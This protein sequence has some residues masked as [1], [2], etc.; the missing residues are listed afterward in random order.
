MISRQKAQAYLDRW[1]QRWNLERPIG[2]EPTPEPWQ[3][4]RFGGDLSWK[5]NGKQD[6]HT[7]FHRI[8]LSLLAS[9]RSR[10]NKGAASPQEKQKGRAD[11]SGRPSFDLIPATTYIPA[12][13]PVQYHRLPNPVGATLLRTLEVAV[14][15]QRTR[16]GS[17]TGSLAI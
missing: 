15:G 12:Q 6:L 7:G 11:F 1:E 5:T 4:S 3:G 16:P 2:I 8:R 14:H 9:A 13:L 10:R 17:C